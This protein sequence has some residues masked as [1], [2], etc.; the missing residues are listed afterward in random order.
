MSLG[1]G[2]KHCERNVSG[3]KKN[4]YVQLAYDVC[5]EIDCISSGVFQMVKCRKKKSH[6]ASH[7]ALFIVCRCENSSAD[8]QPGLKTKINE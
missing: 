1:N 3:L 4:H 2:L 8:C 7:D 6:D 5:F